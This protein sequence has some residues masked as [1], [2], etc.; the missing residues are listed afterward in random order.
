MDIEQIKIT[1]D[2]PFPGNDIE[3]CLYKTVFPKDSSELQ[4][5]FRKRFT[6]N[7]W[8]APWVNGVYEFHHFH[9]EAHEVL[10]CAA[11]W[12]I[13]QT[14]GPNGLRVKLEAGD[15]VLIPAGVSHKNIDCSADYRILG[16]YPHGQRPD[17]RQGDP[18][19]WDEVRAKIARVRLWDK[20]PVTGEKE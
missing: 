20:D 8:S 16:S 19:E 18:A 7:G 17:L 12:V 3:F 1:P 9:A 11:G 2:K 13:V 10:G 15:A 4:A 5:E 6:D 14:G